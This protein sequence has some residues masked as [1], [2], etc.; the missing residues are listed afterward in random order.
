MTVSHLDEDFALLEGADEGLLAID[1]LAV[2]HGSH[3]NEEMRVVGHAD[4]YCIEVV[5]VL[6]EKFTEVRV[7]LCVGVHVQHLLALL[8]LQVNVAQCH[9]V[10]HVSLGKLVDVLLTAIADADVGNLNFLV[11][12]SCCRLLFL[13]LGSEHLTGSK[14]HAGCCHTH[15][16]QEI[17]SS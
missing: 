12:R 14:S 11:L 3:A 2:L 13:L 8:A 7:A 1:V 10:H 4:S 9:N 15:S 5:A 6:V 16:F 17:S